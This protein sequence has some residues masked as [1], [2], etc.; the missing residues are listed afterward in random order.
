MCFF[1]YVKFIEILHAMATAQQR[2]SGFR[3]P[4]EIA[5]FFHD[6]RRYHGIFKACLNYKVLMILG[7]L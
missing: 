4:Q 1:N 7:Y 6:I 5:P 3:D 2:R